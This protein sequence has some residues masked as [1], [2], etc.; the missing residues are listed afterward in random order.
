MREGTARAPLPEL[1]EA[2]LAADEKPD[3]AAAAAE[4]A[5]QFPAAAAAAAAALPS[6]ASSC[7][8][9]MADDL[10]KALLTEPWLEEYK[11]DQSG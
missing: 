4:A 3:A 5:P 9:V 1:E 6:E 2:A 8:K 11:V 10:I 7:N